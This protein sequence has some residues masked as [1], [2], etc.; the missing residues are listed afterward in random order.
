MKRGGDLEADTHDPM[1]MK[2]NPVWILALLV[3]AL[4]WP[5]GAV[6][7]AAQTAVVA[8]EGEAARSV[9]AAEAMPLAIVPRA[10]PPEPGYDY[11]ALDALIVQ[12]GGRKKPFLTFALEMT[13][14]VSGRS[15]VRLED[16]TKVG[17]RAFVASLFLGQPGWTRQ[18]VVLVDYA[19]LKAALGL[20]KSQMRFAYEELAG[21]PELGALVQE[22]RMKRAAAA[23]SEV[24]LG[25]LEKSVEMLATR[26]QVFESL[27]SG[28]AFTVIPDR[29]RADGAWVTIPE[30][31]G[32]FTSQELAPLHA[33]LRGVVEGYHAGAP[34]ADWDA[35]ARAMVVAQ[36]GLAPAV[37]PSASKVSAE[38]TYD[39][40]H[41]FR[42]A[43][44]CYFL[45]AVVF[46]ATWRPFRAMGG[47]VGWV[48][49]AAGLVF[50]LTGFVLRVVV[51]GRA[52]VTNMYE[53][54]VWVAIG[55]VAFAIGF[56]VRYRSRLFIASAAPLAMLL[57]IAADSLPVVLSP[58]LSP[59][60]PVLRDNF[61]LTVHVLTVTTSY[62]AFALA[63][64]V[65]HVA[66]FRQLA[67]PGPQAISREVY[68]YIYW[69]MAV[70]LVLLIPGIILGGVWANYSWGRF[71]GWDPKETWALIAALVYL[72]IL[73]GRL[74]GWWTQFGFAVG[75][76][77]GFQSIIMAWYGV[78]FIIG[79]GLHSYGFGMGGQGWVAGFVVVELVLT[80]AAVAR[81][82]Q[83]P[84]VPAAAPAPEAAGR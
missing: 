55:L 1:M 72:F 53:T 40:L 30:V 29:M 78:N 47:R 54:M 2:R 79:A 81:H 17:A 21:R 38:L 33:A 16:G 80:A 49:V 23:G 22:V 59:L 10:L 56:E 44:V 25:P 3:L 64:A 35:A 41:P 4:P 15:S 14:E 28:A 76:V 34:A 57:M 62:A 45:A 13:R 26:L 61:W 52:P 8:A 73:H 27:V 9:A 7:A 65:A 67:R 71:W 68:A 60:V 50:H 31:G 46:A 82:L 48:L 5:G 75:A 37:M 39:G 63:M 11:S 84:A 18:P 77:L 32:R 70:G 58:S 6:V 36:A 12:H 51:S 43:W 19:P 24:R 83:R 42:W 20:P 69:A 66:L 74:A